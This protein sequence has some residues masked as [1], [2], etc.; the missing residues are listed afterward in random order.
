M[1]TLRRGPL[2][3]VL[4]VIAAVLS[5][6]P[7]LEMGLND[8]W[9]FA[10]IARGFARTGHIAYNGW[11]APLL[12]LQV[13]W[14]G[15]LI[16]AFGFSFTLLRLSTLPFAAGCAVLVYGLGRRAGLREGLAIFGSLT[17]VLSPVFLPLSASFM[18]DL[19]ALFFWLACFYCGVRAAEGDRSGRWLALAAGAGFAGG[20]IRQVVWI[21]PFLVLLTAAWLHRRQRRV[22]LMS[23]LLGCV[24][25]GA[26]L[27]CLVWYHA[28]S[29]HQPVP[30]ESSLTILGRLAE[31]VR[32]MLLA[33]GMMLLPVLALFLSRW[34]RWLRAPVPLVAGLLAVGAFVAGCVWWYED[35]LLLGNMWTAYGVLWHNAE[36][37]GDRPVIL[38][39][40]LL[41]VL[42]VALSMS[43]GCAAAWVWDAVRS[44]R[45][46]EQSAGP[47]WRVLLLTMPSCV[48]YV[49]AVAARY[50][51]DEILFDR[52]LIFITPPLA[53]ALLWLYQA[54]IRP[55]VSGAAWVCLG[56]LAFYGLAST[57]DYIA[58]ARARLEA[59]DRLIASGVPRTRITAGLEFDGW[60]QLEQTGAIPPLEERQRDQR[61]F[62]VAEAYWFW[63]MTPAIDPLYFVVY[64]PIPGLRSSSFSPV[65][66]GA[67]LP[68]FRRCVL[69]QSAQ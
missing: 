61:T 54:R 8:D 58:A 59:A 1:S 45:E 62:P 69:T 63:R 17:L 32:L 27:A 57:H 25:A 2:L 52:Y 56:V 14:G 51:S 7:W 42:G 49:S 23:A 40:A 37:M 4:V 43:L 20:T 36:A 9:S 34:Q 5:T 67:W 41:T 65:P 30:V 28:Q 12:G 29:G 53:I 19:P 66:Y 31:P 15:W 47:L 6:G 38:G 68:P 44:R 13:V 16:R 46:W 26:A 33:A 18:T 11:A 64:S 22:V 24:T 60:T 10:Y 35:D 48:L 39:P 55:T 3:C 21:A 50:A